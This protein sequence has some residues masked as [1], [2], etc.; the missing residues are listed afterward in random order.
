MEVIILRDLVAGEICRG[1]A[2]TGVGLY[3]TVDG[4]TRQRTEVN[5]LGPQIQINHSIVDRR[6]NIVKPTDILLSFDID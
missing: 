5:S 1:R 4:V 3:R 6:S 2:R